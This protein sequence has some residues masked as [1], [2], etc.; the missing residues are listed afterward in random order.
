VNEGTGANCLAVF[1]AGPLTA[2]VAVKAAAKF[3]CNSEK[4]REFLPLAAIIK[5]R[6]ETI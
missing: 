5:I 6:A 1:D 2:P 4:K 3:P